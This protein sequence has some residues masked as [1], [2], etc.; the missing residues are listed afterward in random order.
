MHKETFP[1]TGEAVGNVVIAEKYQ[2]YCI[3][4]TT[5]NMAHMSTLFSGKEG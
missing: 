1:N 5:R 2:K 4:E 3:L